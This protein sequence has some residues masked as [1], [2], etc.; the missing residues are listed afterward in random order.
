[1]SR[2]GDPTR[3]VRSRSKRQVTAGEKVAE[4]LEEE[5]LAI[6]VA[7]EEAWAAAA[8]LDEAKA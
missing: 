5:A 3:A 4:G 8:A 1:M 6:E 7:A 2:V